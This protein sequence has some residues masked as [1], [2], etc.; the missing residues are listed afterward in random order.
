MKKLL[1]LQPLRVYKR[2]PMPDDFTG[3][4]GNSPTLA[5]AQLKGALKGYEC[6]FMDGLA[7]DYTLAELTRRARAA[8]AVLVNA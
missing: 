5:F 6:E 8:D 1:M 3:L 7:G 2:W 4:L